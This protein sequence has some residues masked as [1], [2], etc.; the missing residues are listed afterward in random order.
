VLAWVVGSRG[1]LGSSVRGALAAR[2]AEGTL[3][4]DDLSIPAADD[5]SLTLALRSRAARFLAASVALGHEGWAVLWCAGTAVVASGARE[6]AADRGAFEQ[7]LLALEAALEASPEAAMLPGHILLASSA[8]GVWAGHTG[9]PI[10][11][12]TPVR[13]LSDYGFGHLAREEA[14]AAFA[15]RR[16]GVR[17]AV[18]RLSNLYGPEQRLDKPQ[19]LVSQIAR[20]SIHRRPVRIYV[21][22]DTV[23]DYLFAED[24]GRGMADVL[25]RL[26]R[27]PEAGSKPLLKILA[28]EEETS[29][30]G[31][32]AIF[33]RVT[34]RKVA[35]VAGLRPV[36]RLQPWR[37]RF[38][39][40]VWTSA[41]RSR[42]TP[43]PEGVARI[44]RHQLA[45]FVRGALPPPVEE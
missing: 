12:S 20:S 11:E 14:L 37:L 22:L 8:G 6:V 33:H 45:Q 4:T 32:L 18:V 31:L 7:F 17:A 44:H 2:P 1:L 38:R 36:S 16:T 30:G 21:P 9:Q 19:G 23:R 42:R 25:E 35:V 27:S 41:G 43:L 3:F 28:S 40:E 34:R 39:S 10:T 24:A 26:A 5:P 13:P 15:A 29:I